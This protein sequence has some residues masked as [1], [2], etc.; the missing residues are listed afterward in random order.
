MEKWT[1][2]IFFSTQHSFLQMTTEKA[3]VTE[4]IVWKE[5]NADN[6]HL[7]LYSLIFT[8]QFYE[9]SHMESVDQT[10]FNALT[11]TRQQNFGLVQIETNCRRHFKVH[12]K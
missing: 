6:Q 1:I 7:F 3:L 4:H 8:H 11:I 2:I 5:E 10:S 12:L 9:L